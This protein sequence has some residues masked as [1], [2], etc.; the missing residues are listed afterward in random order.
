MNEELVLVAT[1]ME[2]KHP[3]TGV[4]HYRKE[5]EKNPTMEKKKM[6]VVSYLG[7]RPLEND[8]FG[9]EICYIVT[10]ALFKDKKLAMGL[11]K[12]L[13]RS[14]KTNFLI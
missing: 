1:E 10:H 12:R 8:C 2:K 13:R 3:G 4:S 9:Y 5:L 7:Y 14:H 6:M 11:L